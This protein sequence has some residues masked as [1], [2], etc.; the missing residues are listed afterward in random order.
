M[1]KNLAGKTALI[2]AILVVFIYGIIYGTGTPR[3]GSLKSLITSN[4]RLG[5]DLKGG[6]HLVLEVHVDEVLAST[7]DR[8]VARLQAD[9][10]KAGVTGVTIGKT[11][12]AHPQTI[13]LGGISPAKL[14]DARTVLNGSDYSTYDV[15]S[16]AAG[17]TTL[18]MKQAA[19]RDLE[20][21]TLQ[22][23]IDTINE[24]VN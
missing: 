22:T 4:I 3:L 20:A 19:I 23:S 9:L 17:N 5:L 1:G 11:D 18:V 13:V 24:R 7:T 21:R 14:S 12:P 16:D 8:D 10:P 15:G 2:I 6:T